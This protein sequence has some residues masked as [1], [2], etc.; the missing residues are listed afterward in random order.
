MVS[1]I[2]SFIK[3]RVFIESIAFCVDCSRN[4]TALQGRFLTKKSICDQYIH[5]PENY[6]ITLYINLVDLVVNDEC[7][8]NNCALKVC[9]S[10]LARILFYKI[11]ESELNLQYYSK[12]LRCQRQ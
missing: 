5:V 9:K 2:I 8:E 10:A 3:G 11:V 1:S 6:T 12:G 7:N 4:Y